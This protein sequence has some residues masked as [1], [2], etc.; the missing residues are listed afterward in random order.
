M[1]E[2]YDEIKKG[3]LS[4]LI[5]GVSSPLL[6]KNFE[7]FH[8]ILRLDTAY[9]SEKKLKNPKNE[10]LTQKILKQKH[11]KESGK[12]LL[13]NNGL[14]KV[15]LQIEPSNF[16]FTHFDL[17]SEDRVTLND[18]NIRSHFKHMTKTLLDSLQ[19]HWQ[20]DPNYPGL[21][22]PFNEKDFLKSITAQN[23]FCRQFMGGKVDKCRKLYKR[24]VNTTLFHK[25]LN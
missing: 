11:S 22:K 20:I 10:E 4:N 8:S 16:V 17:E 7:K 25:Y 19:D 23:R 21:L 6:A 15:Q 18:F 5:L 14:E 2:Y 12:A 1:L 3:N 13:L 24:F 9:Y